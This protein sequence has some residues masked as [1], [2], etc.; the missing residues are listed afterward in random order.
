ML[1]EEEEEDREEGDGLRGII[2]EGIYLGPNKSL[3]IERERE[4]EVPE[5]VKSSF[6]AGATQLNI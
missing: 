6:M 3:G 5:A 2:A 1:E 4:R